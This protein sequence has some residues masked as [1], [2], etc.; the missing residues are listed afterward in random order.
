[1]FR[2]HRRWLPVVQQ[3]RRLPALHLEGDEDG[4]GAVSLALGVCVL[5]L[6]VWRLEADVR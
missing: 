1:V 5:A 4:Q 6:G 2:R 3:I